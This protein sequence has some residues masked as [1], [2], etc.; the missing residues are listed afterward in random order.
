MAGFFGFFDDDDEYAEQ[1]PE[2]NQRDLFKETIDASDVWDDLDERDRQD[3]VD[4]WNDSIANMSSH[5]HYAFREMDALL[6]YLE[7]SFE[8]ADWATFR[9]NY[10]P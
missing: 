6:D 8:P 9:E 3:V 1:I 2:G 4:G 7:V 10:H 5:T